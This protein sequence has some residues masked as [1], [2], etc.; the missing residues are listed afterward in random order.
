MCRWVKNVGTGRKIQTQNYNMRKVLHGKGRMLW[1]LFALFFVGII[2]GL[3]IFTLEKSKAASTTCY[4]VGGANPTNWNDATHWSDTSGGAGSTCDGGTVPGADDN[5][6]FDGGGTDTVIVDTDISIASL[7]LTPGYTG[8]FDNA[9]NNQNINVAE[10]VI[11][12]SAVVNMGNGTWTVGGD[13]DNQDVTTFNRNTSTLIMTGSGKNIIS[14]ASTTARQLHHVTISNGASVSIPSVSGEVYIYGTFVVR[15]TLD[16]T[17]NK[18]IRMY[19]ATADLKLI[20]TGLITG[21]G[22]FIADHRSRI[23][24]KDAVMDVANFSIVREHTTTYPILPATYESAN[25]LVYNSATGSVSTLQTAGEYVFLGNVVFDAGLTNSTSN[26]TIGPS[27]GPTR[28]VFKQNLTTLADRAYFR[29]NGSLIV[30]GNLTATNNNIYFYPSSTVDVAGDVT[31][32]C[33]TVT[34]GNSTVWTVGGSFDNKDVGNTVISGSTLVMTGVNKQLIGG[35]LSGLTV[36]EGASIIIPALS[37]TVEVSGVMTVAGTLIIGDGE[38]ID[39]GLGG[40]LRIVSTGLITGLGAFIANTNSK[41]TQKDGIMDVLNFYIVRDHT[42]TMYSI[43]PATY[44]SAN[45]F[46]YNNYSGDYSWQPKAGTY[47]FLGNVTFTGNVASTGTYTINNSTNNPNFVFK[48]NVTVDNG[49][50]TLNWTKGTGT[51][52]FA[53]ESGTQTADFLGL[54][55]EG[56]IVG[57]DTTTNTL[58]LI[59]NIATDQLTVNSNATFD[60]NGNNL[61]YPSSVGT[62]NNG[63]IRLQGNETLTNIANLDTDSGTVEYYG[64]GNYS[65]LPYTG[66]YYNINFTGTGSYTLPTNLTV[67]NDFTLNSSTL[68]APSGTLTVGGDFA[69]TSGT[70]S[71]NNGTLALNGTNQTISGSTTFNNFTKTTSSADTLTFTASSTQTIAG[72]LTLQGTSGNLLTLVSTS[73]GTRWNI[74]NA[75]D[76]ESVSYVDVQDSN[77]TGPT[78][79]AVDSVD[80]GNNIGWEFIAG[81]TTCYWVGETDPAN[82]NDPANWS[83]VSGGSGFTCNGGTV[84]GANNDVVFDGANT[85]SVIFNANSVRVHSLSQETDY[86]GTIY[87]DLTSPDIITTTI[88]ETTTAT[89]TVTATVYLTTTETATNTTTT[90]IAVT[91]TTTATETGTITVP[92]DSTASITVTTTLSADKK[93]KVLPIKDKETKIVY[94]PGKEKETVSVT[95]TEADISDIVI[96]GETQ[97][98]E[99]ATQAEKTKR[100]WWVAGIALLSLVSF[101]LGRYLLHNQEE[102]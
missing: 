73:T 94:V 88:T 32:D 30:D 10:D 67:A 66:N 11:L 84:P 58:Q 45:V 16:I 101:L 34:M 28:F 74:V 44:E 5:V 64:T 56:I 87:K 2:A 22:T 53:K 41:I 81:R 68:T 49:T 72:A 27:T 97:E 36:A 4:W 20:S 83:L 46:F 86:T 57:D 35:R 69:N 65:A 12:D 70:F 102:K 59:S 38:V 98:E 7:A 100:Y 23:T 9:T 1:S 8:T 26:F 50:S 79:S 43:V 51:I 95:V 25:V 76:A 42:A 90:S 52:T 54:A 99:P 77:N 48:G 39:S 17:V 37:N 62:Y 60:L 92:A 13:F 71:H 89:E 82:W 33:N 15:G 61:S 3:A 47:T 96:E 78:I 63:T 24:Q 93:E 85:N 6:V 19:E 14:N 40:D 18:H 55:V 80:S 29:V 21:D 31:L 75:G 91:E